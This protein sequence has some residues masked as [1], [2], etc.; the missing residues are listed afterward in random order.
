MKY[1]AERFCFLQVAMT[2]SILLDPRPHSE[3]SALGLTSNAHHDAHSLLSGVVS[4]LVNVGL[5]H[6]AEE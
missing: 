5:T 6:E 1:Q 2:E 4:W 3:Q